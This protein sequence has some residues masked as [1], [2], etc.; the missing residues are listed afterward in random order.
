[1]DTREEEIAQIEQ[2]LI[3]VLLKRFWWIYFG[4]LVVALLIGYYHV[5]SVLPRP[6]ITDGITTT[7]HVVYQVTT[8]SR[9]GGR[10]TTKISARGIHYTWHGQSYD[11]LGGTDEDMGMAVPVRVIFDAGHPE[12]AFELSIA[13][14]MDF[15]ILKTTLTIWIVLSG[16]L[17]AFASSDSHFTAL[18]FNIPNLTIKSSIYLLVIIV[19]IPLFPLGDL[20]L[21][22]KKADG[23]RGD[24]PAYKDGHYYSSIHFTA[25]SAQ[26]VIYSQYV[27][28]YAKGA[29][30][31]FPVIYQRDNPNRACLYQL[32]PLYSENSYL[33]V[34]MGFCL[35][36]LAAWFAASRM[37]V[38]ES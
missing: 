13:G 17:L 1:M 7:S 37:S 2:K 11:I 19:L 25:D 26:Y 4:S 23:V 29:D 34:L 24:D 36:L 22:G 21:F 16:F 31:H 15:K 30:R 38:Y 27:E 14:L 3:P 12:K 6:V 5:F 10:A 33:F 8:S 35:V 20:L 18:T 9:Y 28:E 32:V